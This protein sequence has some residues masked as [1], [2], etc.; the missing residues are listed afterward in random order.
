MPPRS[1]DD[2]ER[3][4]DL[5]ARIDDIDARMHA[6][7]QERAAVIRELMGAKPAR[8]T[9]GAFRP[10]REAHMMA[11]LADRHAGELPFLTVAHIW[12]TIISTFTQLQAPYRVFLGGDDASLRDMARYQ[13]GYSTP[14]ETAPA[15]GEALRLLAGNPGNL[16]LVPA[17]G[18]DAWWEEALEAGCHVIAV[19]PEVG[20]QAGN[21]FPAALVFAANTIGVDDL[22]RR[23]QAL[24]TNDSTALRA[25]LSKPGCDL[26]AGPADGGRAAL[27]AIDRDGAMA[28]DD[29]AIAVRAAGGTA[30]PVR[31][32]ESV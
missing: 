10:E 6:L 32:R 27:V 20:A 21:E 14:L 23:V 11:A 3:L 30:A 9:A 26:L 25:L 28:I 29:Q 17:G 16:A 5:R 22:P 12:R 18:E 24:R 8:G 7:L 31:V 13:F 4:A 15:R 19:L 2:A 1:P